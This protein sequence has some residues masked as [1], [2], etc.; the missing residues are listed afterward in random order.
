M[1]SNKSPGTDGLT[2]EF[3]QYFWE[4]IKHLFFDS[5]TYA[6]KH[7]ILSCEQRRGVLRLIPKKGKDLTNV[8][9]WRPISLLNTDYKIL[10]HVLANRLQKVLPEVISKDQSGYLKGRNISINIRSIF[11]AIDHVEKTNSSGLLAFLDFEKAFD[12]LNWTF[13]QKALECFGF[14]HKFREYVSILYTNIESCIINNGTTSKYFALTSG[15]R[16][17]CPLSALLFVISAEVLSIALKN[18]DLIQ[19]F[20]L[21]G[22]N[23]KITQLADDTT[24][25]LK[26][27][28]SLK[29]AITMLGQF[30]NISGLKLNQTK[31]EILQIGIPLTSNYS[32]FKMKWEKERIY[33]LG[34]WFYKDYIKSIEY[35]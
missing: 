34:T 30:K 27:I 1:K 16:Q 15:I 3:Y 29:E 17:G 8:N 13:I 35:T 22:S 14:G 18:N 6:M 33:A 31:S 20:E 19:G 5:I 4:N 21:G 32:L 10:A 9:N 23:F 2:T 11:D 26:N 12:K 7:K 25:F 28:E 24:L